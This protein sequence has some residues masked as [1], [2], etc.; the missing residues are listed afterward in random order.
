MTVSECASHA[1]VLAAIGPL[2]LQGQ[3]GAVPCAG[4]CTRGW[5]R[6]GLLIAD[7][8][9]YNW[10]D[11]CTAAD[12]G[13]ALLWRVK[14][15]LTLEPLDLLTDR[16]LPVRAGEP[17]GQGRGPAEDTAG[18]GPWPGR[19]STRRRHATPAWSSTRFP[20]GAAAGGREPIA[21]V[22]TITDLRE[23]PAPALASA[24]HER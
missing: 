17:Q 12:T 22:T 19:A 6:T 24:Y 10:A 7:R 4:N 1:P 8:N 3:R 11:W 5:K 9:F 14:S 18:R 13:A 2:R 23:A 20:T 21:L 15:D 16:S